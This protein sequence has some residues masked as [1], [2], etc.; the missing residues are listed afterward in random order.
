[1]KFCFLPN[2]VKY[3][4]TQ[5]NKD[6]KNTKWNKSNKTL[7]AG[8]QGNYGKG[9]NQPPIHPPP[10]QSWNVANG[11]KSWEPKQFTLENP[12]KTQNQSSQSWMKGTKTVEKN[13]RETR[14]PDPF[15]TP[16]DFSTFCPLDS[17]NTDDFWCGVLSEW[18]GW[19]WV[20]TWVK[21]I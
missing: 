16:P 20:S 9:F 15:P 2:L 1:M 13:P 6:R 5:G 10:P 11:C 21:W 12:P 19:G 7:E 4:K 17:L 8:N 14:F 18:D 3:I